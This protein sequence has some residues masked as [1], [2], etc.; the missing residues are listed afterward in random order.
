MCIYFGTG[1]K[2]GFKIKPYAPRLNFIAT[3]K[4]IQGRGFIRVALFANKR[5]W[6]RV[7]QGRK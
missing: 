2:R 4:C 7:F 1:G 5:N 6:R 3:L